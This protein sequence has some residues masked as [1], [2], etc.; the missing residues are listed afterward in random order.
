[1]N[2]LIKLPEIEKEIL[3]KLKQNNIE[4]PNIEV[5]RQDLKTFENPQIIKHLYILIVYENGGVCGYTITDQVSLEIS[6]IH[7]NEYI[8]NKLADFIIKRWT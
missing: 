4:V 5:T 8:I 3:K 1:M 2:K 7:S 6:N